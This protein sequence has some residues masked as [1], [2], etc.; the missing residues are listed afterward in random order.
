MKLRLK[1]EDE[2]KGFYFLDHT[3]TGKVFTGTS[4]N[5]KKT[6]LFL[7]AELDTGISEHGKLAE[8]N[9]K[10]SDFTVKCFPQSSMADAKKAEK[11]FRKLKPEHLLLN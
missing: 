11:N 8:L 3:P 1:P 2:A 9:K 5:M 4:T 6:L 10:E 7:Q